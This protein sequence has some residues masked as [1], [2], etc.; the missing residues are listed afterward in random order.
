MYIIPQLMASQ[1]EAKVADLFPKDVAKHMMTVKHDDGIYRHVYFG[2]PGTGCMSFSLITWPGS[3]CYSGD[4]GTYVFSRLTD[5]FEFFRGHSPNFQYWAEKVDGRDR[6]GVDEFSVDLFKAKLHAHIAENS[7]EDW[8]DADDQIGE[9]SGSEEDAYE[10]MRELNIH[11]AWEWRF[12][13]YTGRFIWCC[14][15]LPWA[16]ALYDAAKVQAGTQTGEAK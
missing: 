11:D 1:R 10:L 16:I 2:E 4:M 6:D 14:H 9:F 8:E 12:R 5:M 3:L 7:D 15:A 13:E